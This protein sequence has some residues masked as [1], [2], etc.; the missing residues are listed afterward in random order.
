MKGMF[1]KD[2]RLLRGQKQF[3]LIA[4]VFAAIFL[5]GSNQYYFGIT[6]LIIMFAMFTL[7]TISYDEY[8]NGFPFLFTLPISRKGYVREKYAYCLVT[9]GIAWGVFT[10]LTV[11]M[12]VIKGQVAEI[13]PLILTSVGALAAGVLMISLMIPLQLK[14][15]SEKRQIVMIVCFAGLFFLSYCGAKV[16]NKFGATRFAAKFGNVTMSGIV[17]AGVIIAIVMT[18]I[19]YL[20][21]VYIMNK[22]EL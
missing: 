6:Y 22:K 5:F 16:L 20:V 4:C 7:S 13:Q 17:T 18:V 2:L 11:M 21:A 12:K 3:F 9:S 14:F 10:L 1:I 8:D 15:G 19:S